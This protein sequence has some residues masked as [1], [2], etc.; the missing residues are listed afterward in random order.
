M[1]YVIRTR[2]DQ[3]V[4]QKWARATEIS[5]GLLMYKYVCVYRL[6]SVWCVAIEREVGSLTL[7]IGGVVRVHQS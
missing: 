4:L 7:E 1:T 6:V 5:T 3:L 2:G